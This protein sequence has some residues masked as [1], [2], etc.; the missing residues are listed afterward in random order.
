MM[1]YFMRWMFLARYALLYLWPLILVRVLWAY[2][3]PAIAVPKSLSETLGIAGVALAL[4]GF[5][6]AW[7]RAGFAAQGYVVDEMSVP[8][9][10]EYSGAQIIVLLSSLPLLGRLIREHREA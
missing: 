7:Y 1:T 9:A 10:H 2:V 5:A 8:R 4:A 6:L 3:A